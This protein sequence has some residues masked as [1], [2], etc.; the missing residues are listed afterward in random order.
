MSYRLSVDVIGAKELERAFRE[1]PVR[2]RQELKNAIMR[3]ALTVEAKAKGYAPVQYGLLR[4]S[5]N[6]QGPFVTTNNVEASVGTQQEY[7]PHQEYGTGIYG[8]TG[9][10]IRPKRG[11]FLAW[12]GANGKWIFARAVKG[13]KGKLYFKRAKE[14][15][16][17][18]MTSYMQEA[19]GNIIR[20]LAKH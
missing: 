7:A 10:M 2:V 5:I 12:K 20:F 16:K 11:K 9:Q 13:V 15:S 14:E 1:S 17:P 19:L 3:T 18:L 4:G 8:K 6:T